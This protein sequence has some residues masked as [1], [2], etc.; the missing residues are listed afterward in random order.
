MRRL[1]IVL[2]FVLGLAP[3][4]GKG[5]V[6]QSPNP[7]ATSAR[8]TPGNSTPV[9][10]VLSSSSAPNKENLVKAD[11][12]DPTNAHP[13]KRKGLREDP[14]WSWS[15]RLLYRFLLIPLYG[16]FRYNILTIS[17]WA[18]LVITLLLERLIPAEPNQKLFSVSFAHDLVWFIYQPLLHAL[19]VGTYVALVTEV[20]RSHFSQ[21]TFSLHGTPGW[22]RV[23]LALLLV[24]LG[25]W[26]QHYINHEVPFLWRLHAVHHSQKHLNFFTDFRYHPLE[27]VVRHTFI[28]IPFLLLNVDPPVIVAIA[29][30][31]GW[32][33]RFYHGNIR[34]NLG[35]LRYILVTP[36]SHR[37]HHSLETRHWDMNFG[38]LFSFW[39]FLFGKQYRGFDEYPATGIDDDAFP[40]EQTVRLKSLLLTPLS[41]IIHRGARR[42]VTLAEGVT[43]KTEAVATSALSSQSP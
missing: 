28:T 39:D 27:Y 21:L 5:A 38:A 14:H 24:D 41:Q 33:S 31:R 3:N 6:G 37:I 8:S 42:P 16:L 2:F 35:P 34:T 1:F 13:A 32:Y 23:I 19:I 40:H 26:I 25:F 15:K 30:F 43:V 29:I 17:F 4:I 20:Y 10:P 22:L 11:P 9:G 18:V 7:S 36:Q 12:S